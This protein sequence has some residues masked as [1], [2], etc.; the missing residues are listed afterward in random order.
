MADSDSFGRGR[1]SL[2]KILGWIA[3]QLAPVG[4]GQDHALG[5]IK[6]RNDIIRQR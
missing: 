4:A 3:K 6:A 2:C 5:R 1:G